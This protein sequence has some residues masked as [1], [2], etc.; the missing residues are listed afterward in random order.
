M[1]WGEASELLAAARVTEIP[2]R[3]LR[4]T[5]EEERAVLSVPMRMLAAV[6]VKDPDAFADIFAENGSLVQ[7]DD[8][9]R[10]REEI[11][12]YVRAAF[13]GP[14]R[15]C[16]VAGRFL[17]LDFLTDDVAMVTEETSVLLPGERSPAPE[18]VFH[19]TWVIRRRMEGQQQHDLLS[20]HQGPIKG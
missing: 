7:Y 12:A 16:Q 14:F 6:T 5:S 17:Y 11:R 4:F 15:Y 10:N 3:Y 2:S 19:A 18:R 9:L 13:E 1:L 8:E 20:F